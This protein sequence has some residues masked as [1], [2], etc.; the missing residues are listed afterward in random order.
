MVI[1]WLRA[2]KGSKAARTA[3]CR[4]EGCLLLH[5][6]YTVGSG[7]APDLLTPYIY[8]NI[9]WALAGSQKASVYRR[10]GIAPRPEN[11]PLQ[12]TPLTAPEPEQRLRL[13]PSET[14]GAD[15]NKIPNKINRLYIIDFIDIFF[16]SKWGFRLLPIQK[17]SKIKSRAF[18]ISA[19]WAL[20]S[21]TSAP[22]WERRTLA[23]SWVIS[24]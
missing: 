18:L 8:W 6:D 2:K 5:P 10:W 23:I 7:I 21:I 1:T 19:R 4:G 24:R 12:L 15:K 17:P 20:A 14:R 22:I 13:L 16:D 3:C 9:G 11:K